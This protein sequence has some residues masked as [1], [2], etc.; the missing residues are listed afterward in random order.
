MNTVV[1]NKIPVEANI[2]NLLP[3]K[4]FKADSPIYY[5]Y[6]HAADILTKRI[7]PMALLKECSVEIISDNTI[8]IDGHVY[9]SKMLRHLL[10]DNQKV[11]LYLLTIGE[12]PSDLTQTETYFVHSLKLPVMVSAMQELK[13]MVQTEQHIE[14][15]GMV[16]PGLIPDWSLQAN[17][18]IFETFGSTTKAIGMEITKQSLMRPLYSSSG[19]LFEDYHHY[20]ECETCTID[21]CIGREFRFNQTA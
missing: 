1:I 3:Q 2:E 13:K 5:E 6:L 4:N 18:S 17:Q 15:I 9:K 16:N 14:K 12:T 11:F 19:I 7:Q 21:A 20:C 8:L 10:K